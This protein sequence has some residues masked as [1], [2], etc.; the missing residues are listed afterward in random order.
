MF[1]VVSPTCGRGGGGRFGGA[2][3]PRSRRRGG[4]WP[5]ERG[6]AR[7]LLGACGGTRRCV[8]A[9]RS[10][11]RGGRGGLSAGDMAEQR[12][13]M[14]RDE[15]HRDM[16][17]GGVAVGGPAGARVT[18]VRGQ[19]RCVG[20]HRSI[21]TATAAPEM[22]GM[23]PTLQSGGQNRQWPTN[24]QIG[25]IT[26][27]VWGVPNAAERGTK[28]APQTRTHAP[29]RC[30]AS[31]DQCPCLLGVKRGQPSVRSG[32]ST[33][34][35]SDPRT[36]F[37]DGHNGGYAVF[38]G[39]PLCDQSPVGDP[40]NARRGA[41]G[42]HVPDSCATAPPQTSL[43]SRPNGGTRPTGRGRP[44][45]GHILRGWRSHCLPCWLSVGCRPCCPLPTAD[46]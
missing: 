39:P 18:I 6:R 27:A 22:E 1:I 34:S 36:A 37:A 25:Y 19:R 45:P 13:T 31:G 15:G 38:K 44:F 5:D 26:L 33:S 30:G 20:A 16:N 35:R 7:L 40:P 23:H 14:P 41:S 32:T 12:D 3:A 10:P 2:E 17:T 24:G 42:V 11:R 21:R 43:H 28:S 8:G 29:Q 4:A 9:H 46:Q